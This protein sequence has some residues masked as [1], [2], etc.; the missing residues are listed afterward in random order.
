MGAGD[1]KG[2]KLA[3]M[4]PP[5]PDAGALASTL[6]LGDSRFRRYWPLMDRAVR[7]LPAALRWTKMACATRE[8]GKDAWYQPSPVPAVALINALEAQSA[9]KSPAADAGWPK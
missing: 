4:M 5:L 2:A 7:S 3:V 6:P 1:T 8:A 9:W